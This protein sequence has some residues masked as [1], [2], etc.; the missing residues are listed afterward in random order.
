MKYQPGEEVILTDNLGLP[1]FTVKIK[2][3]N[4][5]SQLYTVEYAYPGSSKIEK[6]DVPKERLKLIT[7]G[8]RG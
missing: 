1:A 6:Q 4:P 8:F 5:A 2:N 3:Y 7:D